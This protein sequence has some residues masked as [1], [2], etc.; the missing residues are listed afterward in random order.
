M[1]RRHHRFLTVCRHRYGLFQVLRL[2]DVL[3]PLVE[4][5]VGEAPPPVSY[6]RS[7]TLALTLPSNTFPHLQRPPVFPP[8]SQALSGGGVGDAAYG[9]GGAE[10]GRSTASERAGV[11]G[12]ACA[13][14][15]ECR[16]ARAELRSALR[17]VPPLAACLAPSL[18]R[19]VAWSTLVCAVKASPSTALRLAARGILRRF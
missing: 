4:P 9:M 13:I 11:G 17:A 18:P 16:A 8:V 6:P 1:P 19:S 14:A 2:S 12:A 10:R 7:H 3:R 5:E 15:L